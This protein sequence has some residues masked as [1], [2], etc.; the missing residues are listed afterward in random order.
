[1]SLNWFVLKLQKQWG[2]EKEKKN[3]VNFFL[4]SHFKYKIDFYNVYS[5]EMYIVYSNVYSNSNPLLIHI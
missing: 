3:Q 1:M 5:N 4:I 2:K